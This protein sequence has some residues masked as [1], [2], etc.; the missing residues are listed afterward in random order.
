MDEMVKKMFASIK[1]KYG[2]P[3]EYWVKVLEESGLEKHGERVNHL[4]KEHGFSHGFANLV[5]HEAKNRNLENKPVSDDELVDT[6]FKG[7]EDYR[8][9]YESIIEQVKSFG[10]DVEIA[11][12]KNYVSLR[13]DVQFAILQPSSGKCFDIGLVIKEHDTSLEQAG[14]FNTMC[15]HRIRIEDVPMPDTKIIQ[16]LKDAYNEA[17]R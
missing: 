2:Y 8:K 3:V 15:T 5:A 17:R 9:L 12:K 10:D 13:R 1:E 16:A 7:K 11:P 14:S 4:K 6:M